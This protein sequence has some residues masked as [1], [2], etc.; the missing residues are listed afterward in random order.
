LTGSPVRVLVADDAPELRVLLRLSL[1]GTGEITVVSEA[2][3]GVEAVEMTAEHRPQVIILD[4]SMPL[5]DGLQ[6][7]GEIKRRFPD[8]KVLMYSGFRE[9]ELQKKSIEAGA[10]IYIEKGGDLATLRRSVLSLV[11]P[12]GQIT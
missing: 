12:Q 4:V 5:M 7:A 10:D 3:N 11:A 8:T 6:A 2:T 1:S 9:S